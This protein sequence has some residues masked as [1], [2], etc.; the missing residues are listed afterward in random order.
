MDPL[1]PIV[2][3]LAEAL[4]H[5][6]RVVLLMTHPAFRQPRHSGWGVD[7]SRA[8][9]FRRID[10]YLTSMAVPMKALPGRRPTR[11]FHRPLSAYVNQLADSGFAVDAM[12]E[13]PGDPA[14]RPRPRDAAINR[15]EREIPLFPALR[16]RRG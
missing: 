8:L 7:E 14:L 6:S 9:T 16:A 13:L 4:K 12:E 2:A 15:A 1:A 10:S 5:K 3:S 11:A